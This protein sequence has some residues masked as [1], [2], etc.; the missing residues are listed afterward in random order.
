MLKCALSVLDIGDLGFANLDEPGA[1]D[2]GPPMWYLS[3]R[4][5]GGNSAKDE[6]SIDL[7]KAETGCTMSVEIETAD[8]E[9]LLECFMV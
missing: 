5:A 7:S 8:V 4:C 1:F 2:A 6:S 3:R 9:D